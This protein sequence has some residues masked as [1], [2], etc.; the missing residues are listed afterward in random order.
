MPMWISTYKGHVGKCGCGAQ[1][2]M[3]PA[4]IEKFVPEAKTMI[5]LETM[6]CPS[7]K[8]QVQFAAY[9]RG[10]PFTDSSQLREDDKPS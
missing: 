9:S 10:E 7:C 3:M 6:F 5:L 1:M 4:Q 8:H 2:Q